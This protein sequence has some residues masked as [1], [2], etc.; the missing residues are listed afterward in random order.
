MDKTLRRLRSK[1]PITALGYEEYSAE[2]YGDALSAINAGWTYWS[3]ENF[4]DTEK[5]VA[6]TS[7]ATVSPV[8]KERAHAFNN[9]GVFAR[10]SNDEE[11]LRMP[12]F[13]T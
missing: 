2:N 4:F 13:S 1:E 5:A 11:G 12:G 3:D 8:P 10:Y 7:L 9:L 6:P